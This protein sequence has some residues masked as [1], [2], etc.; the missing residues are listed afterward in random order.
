MVYI[1]VSIAHYHYYI[2]MKDLLY[3]LGENQLNP[4]KYTT[5]AI[6]AQSLG[7]II[8]TCFMRELLTITT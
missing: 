7:M 5:N 4:Q 1:S 8:L 3:M 6:G 2:L